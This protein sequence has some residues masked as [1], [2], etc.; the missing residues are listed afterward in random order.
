MTSAN[1]E[2]GYALAARLLAAINERDCAAL[3][4]EFGIGEAVASEIFEE[5]DR[6][7]KAGDMLSLAPL[8]Q[9]SQAGRGRRPAIDWFINH[10]GNLGME[11]VLLVDGR[12]CEAILHAEVSSD[13]G[14]PRLHYHYI[15]S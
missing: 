14:V 11:C 6:Y 3:Q 1:K 9:S 4:R 10:A 8:A 2:D 13:K 15:G 7:I 12:P 5:V